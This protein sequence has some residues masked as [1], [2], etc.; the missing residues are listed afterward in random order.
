MPVGGEADLSHNN[1]VPAKMSGSG[2]ALVSRAAF[3]LEGCLG[4]KS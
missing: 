1:F 3:C 4:M 2:Q